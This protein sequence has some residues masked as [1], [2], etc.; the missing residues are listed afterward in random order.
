MSQFS[1]LNEIYNATSMEGELTKGP[2][3][4]WQKKLE[5]NSRSILSVSYSGD[6]KAPSKTP[7]KNSE[8]KTGKTPAKTPNGGDRFIP[9]RGTTNFDLGHYLV[10]Q[11]QENDDAAKNN[12]ENKN[13]KEEKQQLI[14]DALQIGDPTNARI[15][16]YKN[17]A[18]AA[19]DSHQNPLKVVY[20][21][22]TP[23]S[24]KSGNRYIPSTPERILDAPDIINDYC[25][26]MREKCKFL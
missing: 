7:G 12:F 16:S 25:K 10:K 14:S 18:P 21:M 22:R 20:S 5:D 26:I 17:K 8:K 24:H 1:F 4:R 3:P 11:E 9:N 13:T 19:P 2:M 23:T 15:L 6:N